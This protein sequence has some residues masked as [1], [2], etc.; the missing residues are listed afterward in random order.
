M[1]VKG[2]FDGLPLHKRD[3]FA[4]FV[5]DLQASSRE[6]KIARLKEFLDKLKDEI[7][8]INRRR[9]ALG[10]MLDNVKLLLEE[11]DRALTAGPQD[12]ELR[13][14]RNQLLSIQHTLTQEIA[15]LRPDNKL[16]KKTDVARR[17]DD[18]QSRRALAEQL[19]VVFGKQPNPQ[20]RSTSPLLDGKDAQSLGEEMAA[21]RGESTPEIEEAVQNIMAGKEFRKDA[22]TPVTLPAEADKRAG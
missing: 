4:S 7:D 14:F 19:Q 8:E 21:R 6:E 15:S 18:L 22:K 1:G 2:F 10:G 13:L 16:G 20:M 11:A 9:K 3:M 12:L 5:G 17:I